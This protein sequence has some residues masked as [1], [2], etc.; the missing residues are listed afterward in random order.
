M[1]EQAKQFEKKENRV[2]RMSVQEYAIRKGIELEPVQ[3]YGFPCL[4]GGEEPARE[5]I[6]SLEL[7]N[8][9]LVLVENVDNFKGIS[10]EEILEKIKS[11]HDYE[12]D[13]ET[14]DFSFAKV[15]LSYLLDKGIEVHSIDHKFE[16][17]EKSEQN[18]REVLQMFDARPWVSKALKEEDDEKSWQIVMQGWE[19]FKLTSH[20]IQRLREEQMLSN[21][22]PLIMTSAHQRKIKK[23]AIIIGADHR[24]GVVNSMIK[25]G[26]D[27]KVQE[28]RFVRNQEVGNLSSTEFPSYLLYIIIGFAGMDGGVFLAPW[29]KDHLSA[30][31]KTGEVKLTIEDVK[32]IFMKLRRGSLRKEDLIVQES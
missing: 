19:D 28:S 7:I 12:E 27:V 16:S 18:H 14:S 31:I 2:S 17:E 4:H 25:R 11:D 20:K 30:E 3:F 29:G 9:D 32:E 23:V 8:P 24:F 26:D 22:A 5:I 13:V 6:S 10:Y 21:I 15:L 1:E